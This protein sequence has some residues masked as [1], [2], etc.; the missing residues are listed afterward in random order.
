MWAKKSPPGAQ[1]SKREGGGLFFFFGVSRRARAAL[2]RS[3]SLF[4]SS[5]SDTLQGHPFHTPVPLCH[6]FRPCHTHP[7][8]TRRPWVA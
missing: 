6:P 5:F 4:F 8:P 7:R 1:V 2:S 3:L